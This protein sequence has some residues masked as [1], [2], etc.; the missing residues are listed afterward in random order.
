MNKTFLGKAKKKTAFWAVFWSG[1]NGIK[2]ESFLHTTGHWQFGLQIEIFAI[3][4][5]CEF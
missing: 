3:Q 1:L 5:I 4:A 2:L